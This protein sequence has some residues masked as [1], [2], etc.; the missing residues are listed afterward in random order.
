VTV[1][2]NANPMRLDI[3]YKWIPYC[4]QKG[5]MISINPDAHRKEG[6]DHMRYGVMT[7]RKGGLVRSMCLNA[8]PL[9]ALLQHWH[10]S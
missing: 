10:T 2:L 8:L 9:D 3:D 5:V 6:F 1:E 4:M 7:A